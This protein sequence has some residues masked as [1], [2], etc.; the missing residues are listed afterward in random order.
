MTLEQVCAIVGD[1]EG[2][3]GSGE[4][5]CDIVDGVQGEEHNDVYV[6]VAPGSCCK[7]QERQDSQHLHCFVADSRHLCRTRVRSKRSGNENYESHQNNELL[8]LVLSVDK[9]HKYHTNRHTHTIYA[10]IQT[11]ILSQPFSGDRSIKESCHELL[12]VSMS[13]CHH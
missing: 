12:F 3:T 13:A 6:C 9:T 5:G 1:L 7:H 4:V 8:Y 10:H 2:Q 11:H